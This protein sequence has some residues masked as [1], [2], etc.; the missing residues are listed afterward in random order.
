MINTFFMILIIMFAL[1]VSFLYAIL[2][3]KENIIKL[4]EK[5]EYLK[6]MAKE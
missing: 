5:A 2:R 4:H 6:E 3:I 1:F